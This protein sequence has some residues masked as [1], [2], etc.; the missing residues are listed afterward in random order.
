MTHK[1]SGR[2]RPGQP[3]PVCKKGVKIPD[4]PGPFQTQA[5]ALT[6]ALNLRNRRRAAWNFRGSGCV[7]LLPAFPVID[8]W[9]WNSHPPGI[10]PFEGMWWVFRWST[11]SGQDISF[12]RLYVEGEAMAGAGGARPHNPDFPVFTW[13]WRYIPVL[14]P[15]GD[16]TAAGGVNI[17]NVNY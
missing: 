6:Y 11:D 5:I 7:N 2:R 15:F 1:F 12:G 8:G 9:Q 4:D 10:F 17:V 16:W 3:P 14:P 13:F